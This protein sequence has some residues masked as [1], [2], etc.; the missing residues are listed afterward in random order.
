M[1]IL[2]IGGR[3]W[4]VDKLFSLSQLGLLRLYRSVWTLQMDPRFADIPFRTTA[5]LADIPQAA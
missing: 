3:T 4:D 5:E 1:V 2:A